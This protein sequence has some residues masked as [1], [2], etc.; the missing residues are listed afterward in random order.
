M[1]LSDP[2]GK[3]KPVSDTAKTVLLPITVTADIATSPVQAVAA[4]AYVTGT[5]ISNSRNGSYAP[6][7]NSNHL[8]ET[9]RKKE[10]SNT[11]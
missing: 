2:S 4:G 3:K 6:I 7:Y 1:S 5:S 11:P 10:G 8:T 9:N